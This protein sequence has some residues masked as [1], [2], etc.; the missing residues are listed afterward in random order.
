MSGLPVLW[1]YRTGDLSTSPGF[2]LPVKRGVGV[3]IV[4]YKGHHPDNMKMD[5]YWDWDASDVIAPCDG[6]VSQSFY[7][8]GIEVQC[9]R[10]GTFS[11]WFIVLLHMDKHVEVGTHLKRGDWIGHP[12]SVGTGAR[13][14]HM[15]QGYHPNSGDY[16]PIEGQMVN[17]L[18]LEQG[19]GAKPMDLVPDG[20]GVRLTSA[21]GGQVV[22]AQFAPSL[23][24]P[25]PHHGAAWPG[26][27]AGHYFGDI[28]GPV[29]SHGGYRAAD[30]PAI[31]ALQQQLI[32]F[33]CVPGIRDVHDSWADGKF[34]SPTGDAVMLAR[35]KL[36]F[37]FPSQRV[38]GKNLWDALMAT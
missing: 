5:I 8:G 38:V 4:S 3:S 34:E 26:L 25:S 36:H 11:G 10:N 14:L 28:D 27:P 37:Q 30:R 6:Y 35:R 17:P 12:G 20:P 21:N 2:N 31:K 33:G 13:H 18:F 23:A 29:E 22:V 16:E 24:G 32:W 15:E 1:P 9:S 19:V 7:P